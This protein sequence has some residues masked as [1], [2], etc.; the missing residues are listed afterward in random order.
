MGVTKRLINTKQLSEYIGITEG[1]ARVWCCLKKLPYVKVG[2]KV[3]FDLNDIDAWVD[4]RRVKMH[5]D[6]E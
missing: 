3:M 6:G 5:P 1:T 4:E 2:R